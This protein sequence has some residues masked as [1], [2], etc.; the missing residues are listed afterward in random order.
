MSI[1]FE[2]AHAVLEIGE[3]ARVLAFTEKSTGRNVARKNTF[4]GR[5][6]LNDRTELTACHASYDG[7]ILTVG[8]PNGLQTKTKVEVKRDY[9]VFTFIGADS[10]EYWAVTFADLWVDIDYLKDSSFVASGMGLSLNTRMAEYPGRNSHLAG[11]VYT[12][13]GT[14][15]AG[16]VII[17]IAEQEQNAVMRSIVDALPFGTLP[18]GAYSG[19]YAKDCPDANR[20]YT[21][22]VDCLTDE[23]IDEYLELL[24]GFGVTQVNLHQA[25]MYRTG[26]FE[27]FREVY[28][29]G[30]QDFKRIIDKLH[31]NGL[32]VMLH[33]YAFFIDSYGSPEKKGGKYLCP[34]P[35]KDLNVYRTFTL[36]EDMDENQTFVKVEESLADFKPVFGFTEI[37]SPVL[38]IDDELIYVR[39]SDDSSFTNVMRSAYKTVNKPHKKGTAVKEL[40]SYFTH[41]M[42]AKDS[43]LFYEVARNTADFYNECGF[44]GFYIDAIDGSLA[45][46]GNEFSWYHATVFV[47]EIFKHLKRPPIFNCCYGPQYPG[48]WFARTLMGAFDTPGRGYRDF[49]DVHVD[50][51]AKFADRMYLISELGWWSLF[52]Y[53]HQV[54]W[55]K[56]VMWPEDVEYLMVKMLA[57]DSSM[58]WLASF[59]QY[60]QVPI[61]AS[62]RPTIQLYTKLRDERYFPKEIKDKLRK[63]GQEFHLT[64]E[65]GKYSFY[66]TYTDRQRI[67]SFEDGRN[68]MVYNNRFDRQTPKIR[69]EALWTAEGYDSDKAKVILK[70]DENTPVEFGRQ[71]PV[72]TPST[73]KMKGLG[74]WIKGDGKGETVNVRLRS[75]KHIDPGYGDHF[76]KVDFTGWR[77][78]SWYELQNCEMK[79]EEYPAEPLDYKVFEDVI[80]FYASYDSTVNM[81]H[82]EMVEMLVYPKG[83]YDIYFKDIVAVPEKS[84]ELKMPAVEING[85]KIYFDAVMHSGDY[86]EYDPK[87]GECVHC[88]IIGTEL[89]HPEVIGKAPVMEKGSN[90]VTFTAIC[91]TPLI[92]RAAVTLMTSG[93]KLI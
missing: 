68:V 88:D 47:N 38:W 74:V 11:Q 72:C 37:Q 60:K 67:D 71:Y 58:C 82:L 9:I 66:R 7:G 70:M 40:G 44:D 81:D 51:N 55:Q 77:Y 6:I 30:R 86:L 63:A 21:I 91:D 42:S 87:T 57:T 32:K 53:G 45:L 64:E 48:H 80:P 79:H 83:D 18:K 5:L 59:E 19:P 4:F 78:Y 28:P 1:V 26:D 14:D 13:I 89:A 2:T 49:I 73:D 15:G 90:T 75:Y 50:F 93:E 35:H 56:K 16:F 17:G 25:K 46:D 10:E 76:V 20:T 41:L 62:Y 84:L 39:D 31:D 8:Y 33:T 54:G 34:V 27:V 43:E 29:N 52:P 24:K 22:R 85:R 36:A 23:N 3:D 69:I 92:K 12:H 65:N 61:L